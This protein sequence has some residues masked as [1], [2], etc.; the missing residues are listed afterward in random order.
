MDGYDRVEAVFCARIDEVRGNLRVRQSHAFFVRNHA[1]L[2]AYSTIPSHLKAELQATINL[3][4]A[5]ETVVYRGLVLQLYGAFERFVADLAGAVLNVLQGKAARYSDLNESLRNAHTVGSARLLSKLQDRNINGVPFN[6]DNLQLNLAACFS[7]DPKYRLGADAFTALLGVCTSERVDSLFEALG[8][9]K[10][11]DDDL[12]RYSTIKSWAKNAGARESYKLARDGLNEL[13][14]L[15]NQIA[16]GSG[17]PEVLDSQVE[18]AAV[19]L[20]VLS[21]A[22]IAKARSKTL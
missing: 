17:D 2:F 13:V 1:Q 22:M 6:F 8:I 14:R 19:F 12:G 16:H 4:G 9:G 10:A 5:S 11:F 15:R 3:K 7:D 20:T 18:E 21:S